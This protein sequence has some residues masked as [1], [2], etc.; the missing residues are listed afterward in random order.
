MTE[1]KRPDIPPEIVDRITLVEE[2]STDIILEDIDVNK[3]GKEK[4]ELVEILIDWD[5]LRLVHD[6][7]KNH[8]DRRKWKTD[9]E[10]DYGANGEAAK[11]IE[12]NK[13]KAD[14]IIA[15]LGAL[16]LLIKLEVFTDEERKGIDA[17]RIKL[18]DVLSIINHV[19]TET[20]QEI[21]TMIRE[22]E[23]EFDESLVSTE[24]R[25]KFILNITLIVIS[26]LEAITS[27]VLEKLVDKEKVEDRRIRAAAERAAEN[28]YRLPAHP[29]SDDDDLNEMIVAPFG[30]ELLAVGSEI[31]NR[32]R[33]LLRKITGN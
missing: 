18:N 20:T 26:R 2:S 14:K 5:N 9:I 32:L 27:E 30:S 16:H 25:E 23:F 33:N 10:R 11:F 28:A 22:S 13:L 19:E 1:K 8:T 31:V 6:N 4:L 29:E 21:M 7:H 17:E 24:S 12:E 3:C 15:T